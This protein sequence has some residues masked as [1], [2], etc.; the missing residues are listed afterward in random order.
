MRYQDAVK[1]AAA[2]ALKRKEIIYVVHDP[3]CYDRGFSSDYHY[4]PATAE[5]LRGF[6]KGCKPIWSSEEELFKQAKTGET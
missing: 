6:F 4:F 3:A 1:R 2:H 5:Q